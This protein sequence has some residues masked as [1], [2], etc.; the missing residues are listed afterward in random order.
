MSWY[1][2]LKDN[3]VIQLSYHSKRQPIKAMGQRYQHIRRHTNHSDHASHAIKG[4]ARV[5][6]IYT[7]DEHVGQDHTTWQISPVLY[8]GLGHRRPSERPSPA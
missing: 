7:V 6:S 2:I 5:D 8:I 3:K 1:P 4:T